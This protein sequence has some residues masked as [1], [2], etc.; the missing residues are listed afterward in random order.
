MT[1]PQTPPKEAKQV[2]VWPRV[3]GMVLVLAL[4][5]LILLYQDTLREMAP[6]GYAGVFFIT[7]VANASVILPLPGLVLPFALG[8]V[9]H[10]F[11]VAMAAAAGA[12]LGELSGYVL[13]LSGQAFVEDYRIYRRLKTLMERY[14]PWVILATALLPLPL[15]DFVGI[16]AGATRWPLWRFLFWVF[17]GKAIKMLVVTYFGG[18]LL[19]WLGVVSPY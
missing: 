7:L 19:P 10:P 18:L 12:T 5:V 16:L 9:L 11:W 13:G 3:L 17:L 2:R 14:G 4:S 15:F 6:Y 1:A 8:A